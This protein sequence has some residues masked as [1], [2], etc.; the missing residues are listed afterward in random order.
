MRTGSCLLRPSRRWTD[1]PDTEHTGCGPPLPRPPPPTP[2]MQVVVALPLYRAGRPWCCALGSS[3]PLAGLSQ[4]KARALPLGTDLPC[5]AGSAAAHT[6]APTQL[7]GPLAGGL[8]EARSPLPG[9]QPQGHMEKWLFPSDRLP[10]QQANSGSPVSS[11][12]NPC[13]H[14]TGASRGGRRVH[15]ITAAHRD[16]RTPPLPPRPA[17]ARHRAPRGPGVMVPTSCSACLARAVP[18]Q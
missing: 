1:P 14:H 16:S 8:Q 11:P 6:S 4:G 9:P 13:P 3:A 15:L 18:G 5:Q 12:C 7:P 2:S 10:I 17:S